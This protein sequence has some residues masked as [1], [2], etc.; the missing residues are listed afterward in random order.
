MQPRSREHG[1]PPASLVH[2]EVE[3][4]SD[5]EEETRRRKRNYAAELRRLMG[6]QLENSRNAGTDGDA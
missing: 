6:R 1:N 5:A 2:G 4:L 3:T